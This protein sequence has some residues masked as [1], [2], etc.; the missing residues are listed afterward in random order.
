VIFFNFQL[1]CL[2]QTDNLSLIHFADGSLPRQPNIRLALVL[3]WAV[4]CTTVHVQD[5]ADVEGDRQMGRQTVAIYLGQNVTR[6]TIAI[7]LV[8]WSLVL[9]W[10]W[11]VNFN[12]GVLY[13]SLG[14]F[15]GIHVFFLRQKTSDER[16]FRI[17]NVSTVCLIKGLN[18]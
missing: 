15:L 1:V 10:V 6:T 13:T 8:L 12:V 5:L 9:P 18:V 2:E 17:Y 4:I 11:G 7:F 14:I 3:S 16:S